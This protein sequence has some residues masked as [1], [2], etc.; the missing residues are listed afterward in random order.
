MV[1]GSLQRRSETLKLESNR[2]TRI[3][4]ARAGSDQA[5]WGLIFDVV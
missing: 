3:I 1:P 5:A 2:V 4:V